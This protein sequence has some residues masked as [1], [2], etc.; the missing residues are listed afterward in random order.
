MRRIATTL[1]L[2]F[3]LLF[4]CDD[5]GG[6]GNADDR[7]PVGKADLVGSCTPDDCGDMPANG[8]C[9]CDASCLDFDDCCSNVYAV[10][11]D[12]LPAPDCDDGSA[13]SQLCDIKPV[14]ED[15][16]VAARQNGCFVCVDALTCE[17]ASVSCD[18]GSTLNQLCDVPPVCDG[19]T[20][21]A[22]IDSCF[23]CVDPQTCEP[24]PA[25][26]GDGSQL[27]KFCDVP[28]IC[29]EGSEKAIIDACFVCVD[30][31]TCEP[32]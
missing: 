7:Q 20:V 15:G 17:P 13:P 11:A 10:C 21:K 6:G 30:P 1:G 28:P 8:N 2:M 5:D 4:A 26:C 27:S 9:W 25:D 19:D 24:P 31:Q 29:D 16:Q 3:S 22:L 23:V 12:D 14:C 18:D 32:V